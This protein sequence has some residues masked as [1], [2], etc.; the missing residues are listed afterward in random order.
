MTTS[1]RDGRLDIDVNMS[2]E[3]KD[4]SLT[5]AIPAERDTRAAAS[6]SKDDRLMAQMQ[7]GSVDAFAEIYDR[8]CARAYR[9]AW[10]I[11]HD[12]DCA[13]DSVQ[14]AFLSVWNGRA[15]YSRERGSLAA[16]LL[17]VVRY[18]AIDVARR[19][20]K[21]AGRRAAEHTLNT[22]PA[23]VNI[24]EQAVARDEAHRL[25]YLLTQLPDAQREVITLAYYGELTH[26]EI[27]TALELPP[28]TVKGRM[29]LGLHKLRAEIEKDA[30]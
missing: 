10:S 13:E 28:G 7:A 26:T 11:C 21:H 29:R 3:L 30:A 19:H 14:E 8:Y 4:E 16:W 24:A 22:H 25:R 18:R 15:A 23:P 17:T 12:E 27:A 6:A 2:I 1:R 9:V 5:E 20:H